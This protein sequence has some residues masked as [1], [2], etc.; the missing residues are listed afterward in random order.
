MTDE[1]ASRRP[2]FFSRP[3]DRSLAAFKDWINGMAAA[4]GANDEISEAEWQREWQAF[5]AG[6]DGNP[7]EH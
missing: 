7:E 2:L 3:A 4:L 1:N 5:W 6:A